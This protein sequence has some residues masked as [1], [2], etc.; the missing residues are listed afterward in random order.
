MTLE[1]H[2]VSVNGVRLH[3]A[4]SGPADAEPLML[5]HGWP[6][7]WWCWRH[8]APALSG[9]HRCLMPDLRGHGLSEVPEEGYEKEVMA[10]DLLGVMDHF[11]L[12]SVTYAGHDWGGW[13]GLILG[14]RAPERIKGLVALS[15][16]HPWPSWHDRLNPLRLAAFGYQLPLSAPGVGER[17]MRTGLTR[18][19]LERSAPNG[20]YTEADL[21]MFDEPMR[22]PER[23]RATV[24]LYRTFLLRELPRIAAG[25]Y[26]SARLPVPT[27]LVVGDRD[28][29]VRGADL[30]GFEEHAPRMTVE[31]VPEAGH[32]LPEEVPELVVE[33]ISE[34]LP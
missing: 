4:A 5:V 20:T 29:I 8:V 27:R 19:I 17:L 25:R 11:G 15:I 18:K 32:F 6:Q 31:R 34:A 22:S 7:N 1:H 26:R 16:P 12:S 14:M 23:A 30:R 13:M 10:D 3:V 9:T 21:A 2:T 33:R 24:A 28:L